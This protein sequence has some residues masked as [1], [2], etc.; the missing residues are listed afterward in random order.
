MWDWVSGGTE[1]EVHERHDGYIEVGAGPELY[2]APY[3]RWPAAERRAMRYVHGRALDVGCGAGRVAL[4]L[5]DEGVE[6]VGLDASPLAVRAAR[7]RGVR[8]VRQ[9]RVGSFGAEVAG[10]DTVI[11]LG[12][13]AGIFGTPLRLHAALRSWARTMA[14]GARVLAGST[15]PH[16]GAAPLLD[17]DQRR[18]NRRQ[19]KMAGQLRLRVR[20]RQLATDWF[21][22]LFLSQREMR[23]LVRGTGWQCLTAV[24][25]GPAEPFVM[26]LENSWGLV[27]SR[28]APRQPPVRS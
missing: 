4:H 8:Q 1:P 26:V 5:Q 15:S 28:P 11:L 12:N 2:L 25:E 3:D 18:A 17:G 20:Y 6:V 27:S 16:G 10:F 19:S 14:P 24:G 13:N 7:T 21:D 23:D 22:W 9:T